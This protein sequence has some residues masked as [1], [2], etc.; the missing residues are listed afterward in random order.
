MSSSR[1]INWTRWVMCEHVGRGTLVMCDMLVMFEGGWLN[2]LVVCDNGTERENWIVKKN[3]RSVEGP[4]GPN[5]DPHGGA[6]GPWGQGPR[7]PKGPRAY[8]SKSPRIPKG[9]KGMLV[10]DCSA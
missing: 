4:M 6:W 7:V 10:Q 8:R 5:L 2:T 9:P 1:N 3:V